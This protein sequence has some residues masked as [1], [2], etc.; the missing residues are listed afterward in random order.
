MVR[1]HLGGVYVGVVGAV[2]VAGFD[3]GIGGVNGVDL[4]LPWLE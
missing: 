4:H 2:G 3:A 1:V